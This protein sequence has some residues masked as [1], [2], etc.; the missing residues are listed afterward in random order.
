MTV[1]SEAAGAAAEGKPSGADTDAASGTGGPAQETRKAVD[2]AEGAAGRTA[3]SPG[4]DGVEIPKQQSA[5]EAVGH[6]AVEGAR[7]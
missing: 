2:D 4:S 3:G 5:G 7:T 6:Q 1:D